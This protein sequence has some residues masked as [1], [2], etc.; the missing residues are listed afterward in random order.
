MGSL[1]FPSANT[2]GPLVRAHASRPRKE[3]SRS[4]ASNTAPTMTVSTS[5]ESPGPDNSLCPFLHRQMLHDAPSIGGSG[6]VEI[7]AALASGCAQ[8]SAFALGHTPHN[9][10]PLYVW[11]EVRLRRELDPDLRG[12]ARP[13]RQIA[14]NL[15]FRFLAALSAFSRL[16]HSIRVISDHLASFS[17]SGPVVPGRL[18]GQ[19]ISLPK[20]KSCPRV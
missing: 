3:Q 8:R 1:A 20:R 5:S 15:A 14:P 11:K 16:A 10:S 2:P 13:R 7:Y 17:R 18:E 9:V 4:E 6:G 19:G 12:R